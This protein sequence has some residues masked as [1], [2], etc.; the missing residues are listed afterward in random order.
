VTTS[1]GSRIS[2]I[3]SVN[4]TLTSATTTLATQ[5]S[6]LSDLDMAAATA[7][8]SQEYIAL[9]AAEQ[10]YADINQLSLFKYLS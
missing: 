8:Y 6:N 3:S 1:V 7:Q 4:N 5:I 2:L 10:S 9:Q